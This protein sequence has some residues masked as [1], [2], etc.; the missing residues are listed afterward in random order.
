[1]KLGEVF[2]VRYD[3]KIYGEEDR[4]FYVI[5]EDHVVLVSNPAYTFE[6]PARVPLNFFDASN[7]TTHAVDVKYG[8]ATHTYIFQNQQAYGNLKLVLF[9]ENCFLF[10]SMLIV[11]YND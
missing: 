6:V 9:C 4:T 8:E 11:K 5:P 2:N 7:E 1:M 3:T 10:P